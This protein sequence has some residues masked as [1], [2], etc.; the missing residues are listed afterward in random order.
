MNS[1]TYNNRLLFR[2]AYLVSLL[3]NVEDLW[4]YIMNI[5]FLDNYFLKI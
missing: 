4:I 5:S 3:G 1:Y 2:A